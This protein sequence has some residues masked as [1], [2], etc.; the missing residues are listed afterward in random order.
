MTNHYSVANLCIKTI[1]LTPTLLN[2]LCIMYMSMIKTMRNGSMDPITSRCTRIILCKMERQPRN[3]KLGVT[4]MF[5]DP[6][7]L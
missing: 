1:N 4:A 6:H 7:E 3:N 5:S 2:L